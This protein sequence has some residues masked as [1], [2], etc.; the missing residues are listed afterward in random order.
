MEGMAPLLQPSTDPVETVD[1]QYKEIEL[2]IKSIN[3]SQ[4]AVFN[5]IVGVILPG[6]KADDSFTSFNEPKR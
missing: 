4:K 3:G 5:A 6:V 1:L 2:A